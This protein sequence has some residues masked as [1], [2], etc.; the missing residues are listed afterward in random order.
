MSN[1]S[2]DNCRDMLGNLSAYID[3]ELNAGLCLEIERHM[4]GCE[5]CR[6]VVD[7]LRN[8]VLLYHSLPEE[9]LPAAVEQR[10]F[11]CLQLSDYVNAE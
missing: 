4:A 5:N 3:H 9:P 11:K 6:V 2:H 10:L 7:T 1:H 8:T